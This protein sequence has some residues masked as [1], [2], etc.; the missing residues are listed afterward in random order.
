[1]MIYYIENIFQPFTAKPVE[2]DSHEDAAWKVFGDGAEVFYK[3]DG[4]SFDGVSIYSRSAG[5]YQPRGKFRYPGEPGEFGKP[6]HPE[7]GA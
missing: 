1:M 6:W 4:N 5:K 7:A 3:A 2:A